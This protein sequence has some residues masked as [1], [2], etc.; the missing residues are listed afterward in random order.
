MRLAADIIGYLMVLVSLASPQFP[1]RTQILICSALNCF[2]GA[3]SVLL[4]NG[5]HISSVVV[6]NTIAVINIIINIRH[7][8]KENEASVKEKTVFAIL[9][10]IG[11]VLGYS[12]PVDILAITGAMLFVCHVF[13]KKEQPMR[14]FSFLN[15]IVYVIYYAL[16]GSTVVYSQL[17]ALAS[18]VIALIKYNRL[19][20]RNINE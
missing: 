9:Y 3:V 15:I 2:L 18:V 7:I 12:A 8:V 17:I 4:L 5:G 19:S 20:R 16:I 13:Q 1:K 10:F 11:G 14:F 6:L